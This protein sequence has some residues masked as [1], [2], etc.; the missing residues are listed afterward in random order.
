MPNSAPP[1]R[2]INT[3]NEDQVKNK[4][5]WDQFW[6]DPATIE[7]INIQRPADL[8]GNGTGSKRADLAGGMRMYLNIQ[9]WVKL[10]K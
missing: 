6:F 2:V 9:S 3:A 7:L 10:D 1:R 5:A 8:P 4:E